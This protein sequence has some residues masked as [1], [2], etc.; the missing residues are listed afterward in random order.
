[1]NRNLCMSRLSPGQTGT[2]TKISAS[3][4]I[5]RR[6]RDIGLIEGTKVRCVLKSPYGDPSAYYIRGAVIAIRCDDADGISV[7]I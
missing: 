4:G 6:F 5:A 1:M 2:V 3:E 7:C